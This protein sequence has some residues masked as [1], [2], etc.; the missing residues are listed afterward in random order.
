MRMRCVPT[1]VPAIAAA[2]ASLVAG[3]TVAAGAGAGAAMP[4]YGPQVAIFPSE[5]SFGSQRVGSLQQRSVTVENVGNAPLHMYGVT[6]NDFTG[7]YGVAFNGCVGVTLPPGQVCRFVL[8]FQPRT[9]GQHDATVYVH[10]DAPGS[11]QS[12]PVFGQGT[13]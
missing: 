11:I 10:D 3:G 9:V 12:V 4:A 1:V 7:A 6:M 5:V 2:V 8:Q 13:R